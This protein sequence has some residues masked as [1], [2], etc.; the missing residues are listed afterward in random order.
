MCLSTCLRALLVGSIRLRRINLV[1]LAKQDLILIAGNI[2][3]KSKH[4]YATARQLFFASDLVNLLKQLSLKGNRGLNA[5]Y[6][7]LHTTSIPRDAMGTRSPCEPPN[8]PVQRW[9]AQRTVRCKRL[10]AGR[11]PVVHGDR[12]AAEWLSRDQ[13]EPSRAGQPALVQGRAVAGDSR[14]DEELV[15]VN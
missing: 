10:L 7:L 13:L 8:A 15:F 2:G 4:K 5:W 6:T 3:L 12:A 1:E 11:A 9:A 14:V